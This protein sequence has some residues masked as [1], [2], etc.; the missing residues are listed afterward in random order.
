MKRTVST[1]TGTVHTAKMGGL[2]PSVRSSGGC[3]MRRFLSFALLI[4]TLALASASTAAAAAP[5][6]HFNVK[7]TFTGQTFSDGTLGEI[8]AGSKLTGPNGNQL[9]VCDYS[10]TGG[11][12]HLGQFESSSFSSQDPVPVLQFCLV[13]Y[14]NRTP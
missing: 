5:T 11:V 12:T 2:V 9:T 6:N 13:N 3:I 14:V 7:F 8:R 4:L 1:M 10:T